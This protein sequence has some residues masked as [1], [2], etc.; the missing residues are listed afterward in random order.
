MNVLA[1]CKAL[2]EFCLTLAGAYEDYPFDFE[3]TA[4]RHRGNR[5]IFALFLEH[6]GR[7]LLNLKCEPLQAMFWRDSFKSVIPGYHMNKEHWNSVVLDGSVPL[8]IVKDMIADSHRL[9][10]PKQL[11]PSPIP[12]ESS[13]RP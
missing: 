3:T 9:T 11:R 8:G 4:M 2:M 5:R 13:R 12:L 6:G 1:I 10:M 7:Q